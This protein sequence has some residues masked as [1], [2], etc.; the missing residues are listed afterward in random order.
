I[1]RVNLTRQR[2]FLADK[3]QADFD[4]LIITDGP[5]PRLPQHKGIRRQGVF[6]LARIDSVKNLIRYLVFTET[7]AIELSGFSGVR[8]ALALRAAGKEVVVIMRQD[9]FL[10]DILSPE[11]SAMLIRAFTARGIH[12]LSSSGGVMDIIGETEVK[13][14]RLG[15][16]KIIACDMVILENITPDLRFLGDVFPVTCLN[17]PVTHNFRTNF[18]DVYAIDALS[19]VDA[20]KLPGN[21]SLDTQVGCAQAMIAISGLWDDEKEICELNYNQRDMLN[22]F[23]HPQELEPFSQEV[24][25]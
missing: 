5:Q 21:Y 15:S 8:A 20:F 23:F 17:I 7:V 4:G 3:I 24:T 10:P 25:S 19:Q 2:V 16:G 12:I 9:V 14:V 11:R 22:D 6:H 13:A 18:P 1:S